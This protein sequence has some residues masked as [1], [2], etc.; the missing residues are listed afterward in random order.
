MNKLPKYWIVKN[1]QSQLYKDTVIK[2]INYNYDLDLNW[3]SYD[4]YWYDWGSRSGAS[5]WD[6]IGNFENN[7][8]LLTIEQFVEMTKETDEFKKWEIVMDYYGDEVEF[9]CDL[10]E[11]DSYGDRYVVRDQWAFHIRKT[12]KK[13]EPTIEIGGKKY[14]IKDIEENLNPL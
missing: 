8:A 13:I 3:N 2:Y 12:I 4:Y 7:P 11:G 1:D 6:N 10:G 5:R 9:I 14:R